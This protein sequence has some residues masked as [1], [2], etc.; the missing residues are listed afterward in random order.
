MLRWRAGR[1]PGAGAGPRRVSGAPDGPAHQRE[2]SQARVFGAD[3]ISRS[4]PT[5]VNVV[6]ARHQRPLSYNSENWEE[7]GC[8][9]MN[10]AHIVQL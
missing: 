1:G 10:V 3:E 8:H 2:V 4:G 5:L 7:W 6:S 9:L